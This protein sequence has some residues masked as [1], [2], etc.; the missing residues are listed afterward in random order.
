M[1]RTKV[2]WSQRTFGLVLTI[3]L[4][5]TATADTLGDA[6]AADYDATLEDLFIH[7]HQNPE[8]S[9]TIGVEAMTVAALEL[10]KIPDSDTD[11]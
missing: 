3:A 4:A 6:I 8:L 1:P 5:T 9:I 2:T 7:F 10:L 11:R